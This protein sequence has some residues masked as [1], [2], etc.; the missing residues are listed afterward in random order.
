MSIRTVAATRRRLYRSRFALTRQAHYFNVVLRN[1]LHEEIL[2][3]LQEQREILV[4]LRSLLYLF[5]KREEKQMSQLDDTINSLIA[6]VTA[7]DTE[8]DS[9]EALIKGIPG[10]ITTAV[11]NALAAGATPA[12]LSALTGLASTITAKTAELTAAVVAGTPSE[13]PASSG[14]PAPA[15]APAGATGP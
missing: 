5:I 12:Q 8:I 15:P 3:Q 13:P 11:Q 6:T 10:L 9:A 1:K 2:K 4:S 7:E 14:A